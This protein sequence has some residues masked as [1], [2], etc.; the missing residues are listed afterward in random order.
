MIRVDTFN[1]SDN[2]SF[3]I[4]L[5]QLSQQQ[6]KGTFEQYQTAQFFISCLKSLLEVSLPALVGELN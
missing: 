6:Q 1:N 2:D 3:G 5:L 4:H